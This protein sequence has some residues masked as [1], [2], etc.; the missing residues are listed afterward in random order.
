MSFG[1]LCTLSAKSV[2]KI[3][4]QIYQVPKLELITET[5]CHNFYNSKT[6]DNDKVSRSILTYRNLTL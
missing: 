2:M 6:K 3:S 5:F 1:C 4:D